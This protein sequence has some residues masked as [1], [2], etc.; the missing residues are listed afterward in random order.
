MVLREF[1]E[2][3]L[4]FLIEASFTSSVLTLVGAGTLRAIMT[5][6]LLTAYT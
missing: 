4:Q 2:Y 1:I 3:T 5:P 6:T